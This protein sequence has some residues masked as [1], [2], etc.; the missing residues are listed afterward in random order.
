MLCK[1]YSGYVVLQKNS[2]GIVVIGNSSSS[3]SEHQPLP[4]K[5]VPFSCA[6]TPYSVLIP[7][8][9]FF[10]TVTLVEEVWVDGVVEAG[11]G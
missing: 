10:A 4:L 11:G 8:I 7:F 6:D 9:P 2:L 1:V 5:V 3:F